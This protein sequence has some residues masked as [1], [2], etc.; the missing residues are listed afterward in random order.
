MDNQ[1]QPRCRPLSCNALKCVL[2]SMSVEKRQEIHTNLPS[3]HAVNSVLPYTIT[4]VGIVPNALTINRKT[5]TFRKKQVLW[6]DF[7]DSNQTTIS[8]VDLDSH[9]SSPD[10]YVNKSPD[11]AFEK[12]FNVYVKN[13]SNIRNFEIWGLPEFLCERD[14]SDGFKLN[15]SRFENDCCECRR[16]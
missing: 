6:Y 14:G 15:I 12:C 9:K 7:D 2:K 10:F 1:H 11:E 5:W 3:L 4:T 8:I 13:N 16:V